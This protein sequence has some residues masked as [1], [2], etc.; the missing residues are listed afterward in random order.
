ML[1]QIIYAVLLSIFI[2][3]C[4]VSFESGTESMQTFQGAGITFKTPLESNSV[5][6]SD[7]GINYVSETIRAKTNGKV[8]YINGISYGSVKAGDVVNFMNPS[9]ILVN[10]QERKQIAM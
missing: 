8:L 3:S 5:S 9:K 6:N 2:T 4:D 1:Q 7:F 10:G